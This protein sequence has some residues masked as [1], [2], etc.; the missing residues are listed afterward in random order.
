MASSHY[1]GFK[2]AKSVERK[3]KTQRVKGIHA[4]ELDPT[5]AYGVPNLPSDNMTDIM[6]NHFQSDY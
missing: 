1:M 4:K 6:H 2:S 5:R 3:L